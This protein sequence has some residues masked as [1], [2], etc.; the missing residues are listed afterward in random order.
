MGHESSMEEVKAKQMGHE[1]P[2]KEV[3]AQWASGPIGVVR[4][5]NKANGL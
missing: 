3:R 4:G 5:K 2:K 1:G